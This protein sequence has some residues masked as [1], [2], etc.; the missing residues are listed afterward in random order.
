MKAFFYSKYVLESLCDQ[1]WF[2][3]LN[4]GIKLT[5]VFE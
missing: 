5:H 2:L 4:C 1:T 3:V